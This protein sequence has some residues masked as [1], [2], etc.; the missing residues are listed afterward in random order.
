MTSC[1]AT[2]VP[3]LPEIRAWTED[4]YPFLRLHH[5]CRSV[6]RPS[7]AKRCGAE[8]GYGRDERVCIVTVGGSG[9][10]ESLLRRVVESFARGQPSGT[11]LRMVVVA[12]PRIDQADL[13]G[14]RWVGGPRVR[15]GPAGATRGLRPRD[16]AGWVGDDDGAN[17]RSAAVHL[18]PVERHFEQN[19]HVRYRLERHR[20]GRCLEFA[21]ATPAGLAEAIA[22]ETCARTSTTYRCRVDGAARAAAMIAELL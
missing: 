2:S 3:D 7:N 12:G 10:G 14:H 5:R 9:V 8:L 17:R 18:R 1:P 6:D 19:G 22:E 11:D 20:A 16:R 13:S 15:A 21:D 4:H